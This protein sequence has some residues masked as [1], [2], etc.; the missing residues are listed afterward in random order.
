M[1]RKEERAEERTKRSQLG[2]RGISVFISSFLVSESLPRDMIMVMITNKREK[3]QIIIHK[4]LGFFWNLPVRCFS[5]SLQF[6]CE[7]VGTWFCCRSSFIFTRGSTRWTC[8]SVVWSV[9]M[10]WAFSV[11]LPPLQR[12]FSSSTWA[13]SWSSSTSSGPWSA[14][15]RS[16]FQIVLFLLLFE[17]L[18]R[19]VRL[20]AI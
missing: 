17:F 15:R 13:P 10:T 1:A 3:L 14:G 11:L 6:N 16:S 9:V 20:M 12:F 7:V 8:R 4:S 2:Q 5:R 18:P 19:S